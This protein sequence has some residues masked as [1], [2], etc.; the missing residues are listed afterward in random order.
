M[1]R[2]ASERGYFSASLSRI[3]T[4]FARPSSVLASARGDEVS[5]GV[6]I[7]PQDRKQLTTISSLGQNRR[8]D[9]LV[10]VGVLLEDDLPCPVGSLE[11]TELEEDMGCASDQRF[12]STLLVEAHGRPSLTPLNR[13]GGPIDNLTRLFAEELEGALQIARL[14][15]DHSMVHKDF[16][17]L[18][19][20]IGYIP[21]HLLKVRQGSIRFPVLAREMLSD[22]KVDPVTTDARLRAEDRETGSGVFRVV[23]Q[24]HREHRQVVHEG[25]G[26][27]CADVRQLSAWVQ[28]GEEADIRA[29]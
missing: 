26:I 18:V 24:V 8:L 29:R 15:E 2:M 21:Q 7:D 16:S 3:S 10:A 4:A 19:L 27:L 9:V 6:E 14:L 20:A 22:G 5:S 17:I 25:H 13:V 23:A 11:T 12:S 28:L 1:R